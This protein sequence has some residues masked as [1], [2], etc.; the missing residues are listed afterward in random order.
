MQFL[1]RSRNL[2]SP[3]E[4]ETYSDPLVEM[5][6]ISKNRSLSHDVLIN[7]AT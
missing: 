4:E 7:G 6:P 2:P 1:E 5:I 3:Y